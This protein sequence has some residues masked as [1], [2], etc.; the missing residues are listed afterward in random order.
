[1]PPP[2]SVKAVKRSI[3]N[4]ENI[5][6]CERTSLFLTT[7]SES[8]MDDADMFTIQNGTGPGSN[9]QEPLAF[10]AKLSD[11]ERSALESD[12]RVRLA[13]TSKHETIPPD[14]RH[15]TS[16]RHPPSTFLFITSFIGGSVLC[17]LRRRLCNAIESSI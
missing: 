17:G 9:P 8:P 4:V 3:A 7:Y 14:I 16:I 1:V 15:G 6:H 2:R 11:S 12:G 5:K 10:V 13:S